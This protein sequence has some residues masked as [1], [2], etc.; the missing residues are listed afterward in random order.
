MTRTTK[1][2]SKHNYTLSVFLKHRVVV[3]TSPVA[4]NKKYPLSSTDK[5]FWYQQAQQQLNDV[6]AAR[7]NAIKGPAKNVILFVGD[8]MGLTTI[9]A[10][11]ILKGQKLGYTGEEYQ[12][13][14]E[15]FP[16]VALAKVSPADI[17]CR[18]YVLANQLII[19]IMQCMER[20]LLWVRNLLSLTSVYRLPNLLL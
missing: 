7:L 2:I 12:L 18:K 3:P 20:Q 1:K 4:A 8:G 19:I 9:T 10:G 13:A 17:Q 6:L 11:R 15:K 16:H 14:F 5:E